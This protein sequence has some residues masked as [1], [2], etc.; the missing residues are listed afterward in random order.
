MLIVEA[1]ASFPEKHALFQREIK[2]CFRSA[3]PMFVGIQSSQKIETT[4]QEDLY[5]QSFLPNHK[6]DRSLGG[7]ISQGIE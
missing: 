2:K 5:V 6:P 4:D 3:G 1:Q 7:M